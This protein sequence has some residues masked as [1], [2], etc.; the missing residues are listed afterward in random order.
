MKKLFRPKGIRF[1]LILS[2]FIILL[3]PGIIIG[4]IT[5][6][7][8]LDTLENQQKAQV[9]EIATVMNQTIDNTMELKQ[10]DLQVLSERFYGQDLEADEDE[11]REVLLQ[12]EELHNE[13]AQVYLGSEDGSLITQPVVQLGADFQ[14]NERPW[15]SDA[16]AAPGEIIISDPYP[17]ATGEGQVVTLSTALKDGSGVIGIDLSIDFVQQLAANITIGKNGYAILLDT[18]QNF[19]YHPTQDAG[20]NASEDFYQN[21]FETASGTFN[22]E[23]DNTSKIMVYETNELTGWKLA[24]TIDYSE[25]QEEAAATWTTL[26]IVVA[27]TLLAGTVIIL[28]LIRSITRPIKELKENAQIISRG[29]LTR[30]IQIKTNDEIG[31]LSHAFNEMQEGLKS[32]VRDVEFNAQQVA[33]SAEELNANADQMTS[34]SEQVSLAIQEVSASSETQLSRT[35][36]SA[37]SLEEVSIGVGRIVESSTKVADLVNQMSSQADVGGK[38]VS[39]TLNQMTSI[40][41]SVENTNEN[42]ASLLERSKEVSTILKA[43]TDISEQTNLLALNAAIE[44]ARAGEHGKGFAVVAD[45][46]RKLAEQ[47][48]TSANEISAIVHGIQADVQDAVGKMSQVTANVDNGLDV[49]YDAIDKFG[50]ILRSSADIKPQMEEVKAISEQ[51]SEAV[52]G[53]TAT[54]TDLASIAR[55]NA[56]SSEEVAA[57]T[58]E[59]LA[60]MEEISAAA[61]SLTDMAEELTTKITAYKF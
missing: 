61:K 50:E 14:L 35:E 37:N 51:M 26:M 45:E 24:G 10:H 17:S 55:N 2:F 34:S 5:Y 4:A 21:L 33:A 8:S 16:L 23:D 32:L 47:S 1:K 53:V 44:A 15:F 25:I 43:I 11:I 9:E 19:I 42:I 59:Q 36:Q 29:D 41:S 27:A 38:A 60:A 20:E 3:T 13:V 39:D 31:E 57:S 40:Q 6:N 18:S 52:Q 12:Y 7:S 56:A 30:S 28:F 54:A 46:V 49:S 58:E 48:K 22:Y